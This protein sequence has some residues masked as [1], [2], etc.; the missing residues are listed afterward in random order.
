MLL[1]NYALAH[2]ELGMCHF[3]TDLILVH[4]FGVITVV[5]ILL[6]IAKIKEE[7][8]KRNIFNNTVSQTVYCWLFSF[9]MLEVK[10]LAF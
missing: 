7:N 1:L 8:V 4:S 9:Y 10:E 6:L 5:S 2:S 3:T